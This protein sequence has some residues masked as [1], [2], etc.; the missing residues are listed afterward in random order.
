LFSPCRKLH[1][2]N[3]KFCTLQLNVTI[4]NG[5]IQLHEHYTC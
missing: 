3:K 5:T 2:S 4:T 1:Q